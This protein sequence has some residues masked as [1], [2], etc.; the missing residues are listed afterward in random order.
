[1]SRYRKV[2]KEEEEEEEDQAF[3]NNVEG[4]QG[5]NENSS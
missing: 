1:M 5:E 4:V 2:H 3:T